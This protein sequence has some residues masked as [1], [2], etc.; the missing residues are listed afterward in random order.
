MKL[1]ITLNLFDVL[2]YIEFARD[3]IT[4]KREDMN[5]FQKLRLKHLN[6]HVQ[7]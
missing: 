4:L 2:T 7:D 5:M 1:M 6:S 3:H